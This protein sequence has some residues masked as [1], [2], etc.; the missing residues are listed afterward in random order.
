MAD[1]KFTGAS[2]SPANT[3]QYVISKAGL[4]ALAAATVTKITGPDPINGGKSIT[5]YTGAGTPT[6]VGVG[7]DIK[8]L[9]ANTDTA[10]S[11][12]ATKPSTL[13]NGSFRVKVDGSYYD[14]PIYNIAGIKVTNAANADAANLTTTTNAVAYYTN[15]TG[16]FGSK[17]SANGALYATATNGT[18]QWGTLPVAQGGTGC[19]SIDDLKTALGVASLPYV[20]LDGS[21]TMT[22]ALKTNST[23]DG[24]TGTTNGD[25]LPTTISKNTGA[26]IYTK[27]GICAEYNI[28]AKRVFN[29]VFNDYAE[30]R[31]TIDLT[32][33]HVVIDKDDG[34][35]VCTSARLQP[36]AQVISDTFGHSMGQTLKAT[37][38]I[39][40]AGRAL[41]YTYQPRE[42]YHA[43]M[44]VCSA[45]NG[46]VDV[47]TR[48][49]I[50]DYPDCIVGIV[51]E[52]PEYETWGSDNV[53]V[54]GR[55]W[56]RIK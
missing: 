12:N 14:I 48:E 15:T 27:G 45:P 53:K 20:K 35:L 5:V 18:L 1:I 38:P 50:R 34:S 23:A 16:T 55:I 4:Q 26:S 13:A 42:N 8:F 25:S 19:T 30:Y 36:G 9:N 24:I 56:V 52:I 10:I 7:S 43:G 39:A 28:W 11:G 6:T 29:A 17:A 47:M 3:Q 33:G 51:S 21:T 49:E 41:V 46:T 32:P 40:V 31:T 54:D 2:T 37:T 44:A 22:G